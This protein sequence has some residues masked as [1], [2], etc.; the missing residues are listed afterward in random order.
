MT[1]H[2]NP[3]LAKLH[4]LKDLLIQKEIPLA[5][6]TNDF[7][8][9]NLISWFTEMDKGIP[10]LKSMETL[11]LREPLTRS[12]IDELLT[13]G[14]YTQL[15]CLLQYIENTTRLVTRDF[16]AEK[17]VSVTG[18]LVENPQWEFSADRSVEGLF[19]LRVNTIQHASGVW[20]GHILYSR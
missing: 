11:K 7:Y 2:Y 4:N 13:G 9:P 20:S 19:S 1:Q 8:S 6:F 16:F 15:H 17:G 12:A 5:L 10:L 18:F 14:G 3:I